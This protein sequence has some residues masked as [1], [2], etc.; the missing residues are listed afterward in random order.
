MKLIVYMKRI[1]ICFLLN[2]G[3]KIFT[4]NILGHARKFCCLL[5]YGFPLY[6]NFVTHYHALF[7]LYALL[8][9]NKNFLLKCIVCFYFII[10]LQE[11]AK[12]RLSHCL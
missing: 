2:I 9:C 10:H 5:L 3:L 11:Y 12:N 8:R 6:L 7:N 1:K 4:I